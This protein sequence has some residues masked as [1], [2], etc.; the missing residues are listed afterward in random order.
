MK[1]GNL[2][3]YWKLEQREKEEKEDL[4]QNGKKGKSARYEERK[5]VARVR[6]IRRI[7]SELEDTLLPKLTPSFPP[8]TP[9]LSILPHLATPVNFTLNS[10]LQLMKALCW[11]KV[12]VFFH[13]QMYR[14][15]ISLQAFLRKFSHLSLLF[16]HLFYFSGHIVAF[17]HNNVQYLSCLS[18]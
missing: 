5:M 3:R 4:E 1:A 18:M 8:S 12:L 6:K 16:I 14:H 13:F 15:T 10:T 11:L 17:L 2:S 7:L 9:L